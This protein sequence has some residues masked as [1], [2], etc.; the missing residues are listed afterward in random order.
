MKIRNYKRTLFFIISIGL[1]ISSC[2]Q[3]FWFRSK[4]SKEKDSSNIEKDYHII[5]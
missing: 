5:W 4:V 1:I 3:R 2:N